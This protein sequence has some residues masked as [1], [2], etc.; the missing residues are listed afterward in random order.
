[1]FIRKM[2]T[3][4]DQVGTVSAEVVQKLRERANT[5]RPF[6]ARL[7]AAVEQFERIQLD[8]LLDRALD[9]W[10]GTTASKRRQHRQTLAMSLPRRPLT[11]EE[12]RLNRGLYVS[13]GSFGLAVAGSLLFPPLHLLSLVGMLYNSPVIY[14][15]AYQA[16]Q[17]EHT[18]NMNVLTA[19]INTAYI[20]GGLFVW[21][22]M[23]QFSYFFS[24]RLLT[25]IQDRFAQE[26]TATFI[27]QSQTVW[28]LVD[29]EAVQ[30]QLETLQAG[31]LVLARAGEVIPV[32]GTVLEGI[33]LVDQ[34]VL[35][36]EAEPIEKSIGAPVLAMTL[37]LTGKLT[38]QVEKAG[39]ATTAAQIGQLLKHTLDFRTQRQLKALK[40]TDR[41]VLPFLT[42]SAVSLPW[43]GAM[44]AAAVLDAHP[45]RHL[46]N[47]G[48]L[49][50]LNFL[51]LAT[52]QGI[53]I[54]DGRSLEMLNDVD[55][56]IFDKTGTLTQAQPQVTAIH[57]C[58]DWPA[59]QLLAYVAAAEQYQDHPI[60]RALR[61]EAQVRQLHLPSIDQAT[62]Q[63]GYG[64]TVLLNEQRVQIGSARFIEQEGIAIPSAITQVQ[65]VCRQVGH[66]LVFVAVDGQLLGAIELQA[67]ARP[68]AKAL[69]A[70]LRQRPQFKSIMIASGDQAAPTAQLAQ[71]LGVTDYVA[72]TLPADKAALIARLQAAG[73]KVCFVG[74]GINDAVALKQADVSISLRGATTAA[75]DTAHI[76]L[77]DADLQQLLPLFDLVQ[78]F[79]V[80][81]RKLMFAVLTP[82]A[83]G[84]FGIFF[85]GFGLPHMAILD[86]LDVLLGTN[87]VM[88]PWVHQR[89]LADHPFAADARLG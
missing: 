6:V 62:Y 52:Q 38:I 61:A 73:R 17:D 22:S 42:L 3:L 15:R 26:V 46:I 80:N 20:G 12:Q 65:E 57:L 33:A 23:T 7:W 78:D 75:T 72:E 8:P 35:T 11:P 4:A 37:V 19:L 47:L 66:S 44:R 29:G 69:I 40:L 41:L 56:L 82:G 54:K 39:G 13:A 74:D 27:L 2:P 64:L 70:A 25:V 85:L 31:D 1:M 83:V 43:L 86:L 48:T 36:G 9:Q 59:D 53:L 88:R 67:T 49:G 87:I 28:R 71:E 68:E 32:D 79:A 18:V 51:L 34:Q 5:A 63:V 55:T 21:G 30:V 76:V 81:Q 24:L 10:A 84:L 60:A 50:A 77:M 16:L 14:Q 45:Q 89:R 58:A